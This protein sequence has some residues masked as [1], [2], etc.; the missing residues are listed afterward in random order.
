ME[1]NFSCPACRVSR[2]ERDGPVVFDSPH[3]GFVLPPDFRPA[4]KLADIRTTCDSY[5]DELCVG[6]TTAG[7]T[8]LAATFPRAYIDTNR[9]ANDIDPAV[10]ETAWPGQVE[11]SEHSQRG[12]GL[13]RRFALPGVPMYD[14]PL[15]IAEIEGRIENYYTPYRRTLAALL[16]AAAARHGRV[17]HFNMHSMKSKGNAM[18][19]DT[20]SVRPDLV[21]GDRL[22]TTAPAGLTARVAA[23]FRARGYHVA[24]NEPYRGA[25]IVRCHGEPVRGRYSLQIEINRRLYMDETTF[26]RGP[27][28]AQVQAEIVD[29]ARMIVALAAQ[30][31]VSSAS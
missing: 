30:D 8:L 26:E 20:G 1:D 3:S 9:A 23:F 22:G 28:F 17:W 29:F 15:P 4:A 18:N 19:R 7:A 24:I 14:R 31:V 10:V 13:I 5:V 11:L 12:M 21:I 6:V 16:D 27:R 25:D 2:P